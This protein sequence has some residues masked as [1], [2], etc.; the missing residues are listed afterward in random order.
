MNKTVKFILFFVLLIIPQP[1]V[2]AEE[3][4]YV[5]GPGDVVEISVWKDPELTKQLVVPPDGVIS[6]PLVGDIDV[7]DMT[8]AD[9]RKS[10]T[11]KLSE[12]IP[13]TTVSVLLYGIN[14]MRAYVIGKVNKPGEFPIT[15]ESN[16][17]QTLAMAGGLNPFASP[18]KIM[19]LRQLRGKT[20]R[21]PFDYN[22]VEKGENLE[23][24][25]I[26]QRGD[27]VVVP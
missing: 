22:E 18:N 5:I 26:L 19:V 7:S 27:V 10:V 3:N 11:T 24:N 23:Q 20:I 17:M 16:V 21:I 14:S 1:C 25:I 8:V 9:L 4:H 12:Y 15:M 13:D 2:S 6:F